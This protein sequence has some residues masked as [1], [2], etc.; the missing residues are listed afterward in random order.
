MLAASEVGFL[1][2]QLNAADNQRHQGDSSLLELIVTLDGDS[3]DSNLPTSRTI[4]P[5][6]RAMLLQIELLEIGTPSEISIAR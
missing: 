5:W 1:L 4:T 2:G 3:Q 6:V